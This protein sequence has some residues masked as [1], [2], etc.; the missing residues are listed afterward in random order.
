MRITSTYTCRKDRGG[1]GKV[2]TARKSIYTLDQVT[3]PSCGGNWQRA[4]KLEG[5]RR[6]S[7]IE[8]HK[9]KI[10]KELEEAMEE[11]D[12]AVMAVA[13]VY[14]VPQGSNPPKAIKKDA[15]AALL[16][17]AKEARNVSS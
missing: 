3:C 15:K 6:I 4:K 5:G 9:A 7:M 12:E 13:Q 8:R 10:V 17:K 2:F 14:D 16:K 11:I 1:C